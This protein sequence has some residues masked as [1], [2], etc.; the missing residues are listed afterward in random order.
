MPE[1]GCPDRQSREA[2]VRWLYCGDCQW[3]R[4]TLAYP[5]CRFARSLVE[6]A[7][8]MALSLVRSD[9]MLLLSALRVA[10]E[11]WRVGLGRLSGSAMEKESC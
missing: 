11:G 5:R 9:T 2:C 7:L 1:F 4:R 3:L 10:A 6:F 8:V